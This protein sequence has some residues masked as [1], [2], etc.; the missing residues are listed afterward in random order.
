MYV[1]SSK[2]TTKKIKYSLKIIK[3]IKCDIRKIL[4]KYDNEG[5]DR[6]KKA[7]DRCNANDNMRSK[8][9]K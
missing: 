8:W 1:I 4:V 9:I 6:N 3:E 2:S 7:N 5:H